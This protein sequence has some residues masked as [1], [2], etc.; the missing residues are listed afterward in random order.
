MGTIVTVILSIIVII[1][2]LSVI[3]YLIP[4][5]IFAGII[6]AIYKYR[7][8][9]LK[10]L[11]PVWYYILVALKFIGLTLGYY[12]GGYTVNKTL[13]LLNLRLIGSV[14]FLYYIFSNYESNLAT[15]DKSILIYAGIIL[16][17]KLIVALKDFNYNRISIIKSLHDTSYTFLFSTIVAFYIKISLEGNMF[18]EKYSI[19]S[20]FLLLTISLISSLSVISEIELFKKDI[21][22]NILDKSNNVKDLKIV[23]KNESE[24]NSINCNILTPL[25]YAVEVQNINMISFLLKQKVNLN[26]K[27]NGDNI[28]EFAIKKNN[29]AIIE[30]VR[31][32]VN[33]YKNSSNS[34]LLLAKEKENQSFDILKNN[35]DIE[36]KDINGNTPFLNCCISGNISLMKELIKK[37]CNVDEKNYLKQSGLILASVNGNEKILKE[38]IHLYKDVNY[39]DKNCENAIVYAFN[40]S[41]MN[42]VDILTQ[43]GANL[44]SLNRENKPLS[45]ISILKNNMNGLLFLDNHEKII[46]SVECENNLL[47]LASK[48]NNVGIVNYLVSKNHNLNI[49]DNDG[50]N[51]LFIALKNNNLEMVRQFNKN[52]F[53]INYVNKNGDTALS[54][55]IDDDNFELIK[56]LTKFKDI[57]I[58]CIDKDKN[59]V[60]HLSIIKEKSKLSEQLIK[61][62]ITLNNTNDL[63]ESPLHIAAKKGNDSLIKLLLEKDVITHIRDGNGYIPLIHAVKSKNLNS[64][65]MLIKYTLGINLPCKKGELVLDVAKSINDSEIFELV[66]ENFH[67]FI[68]DTKKLMKAALNNEY[69]VIRDLLKNGVECNA[70]TREGYTALMFAASNGNTESIKEL[71]NGSLNISYTN[72]NK[73]S[74]IEC[75]RINNH[76]DIIELL[77]KEAKK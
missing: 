10:L 35:L 33:E 23:I 14:V 51:G 64:I 39:K 65:K 34:L 31:N 21:I 44:D 7:F 67:K 27:I 45:Y 18:I 20:I 60:L 70:V 11:K 74:A 71:L 68:E 3:A 40:N 66:K 69:L 63:G 36:Y 48:L 47:L 6:W 8:N 42:I 26:H 25:F 46:D 4:I 72:E 17:V 28:L 61:G 56:E 58:D 15:S 12:V 52:D 30:I 59:S 2:L 16:F 55:A 49:R 1:L 41:D 53:D 50:N 54:I 37:N 9:I 5:A 43:Y 38:I 57:N 24:L 32:A 29:T 76:F 75:A 62:N 13:K 19:Y 77:E 22:K 73:I